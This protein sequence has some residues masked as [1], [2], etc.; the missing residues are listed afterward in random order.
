MRILIA[1]VGFS[2]YIVLGVLVLEWLR[3]AT[4]NP[5]PSPV[6]ALCHHCLHFHDGANAWCDACDFA[7][8]PD[9][10]VQEEIREQIDGIQYRTSQ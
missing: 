9:G 2:V 10:L 7:I 5:T 1:F 3:G 8:E 4:S 6:R